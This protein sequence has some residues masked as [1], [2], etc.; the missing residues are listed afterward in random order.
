M[1]Y[2]NRELLP[3][4]WGLISS[5]AK[6]GKHGRISARAETLAE[7][8]AFRETFNHRRCTVPAAGSSTSVRA[9]RQGQLRRIGPMGD[10]HTCH[11][12]EK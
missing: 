3:A 2:E 11:T 10:T 7:T 4:K 9:D 1:Q 6:D 12:L 8:A 5:W